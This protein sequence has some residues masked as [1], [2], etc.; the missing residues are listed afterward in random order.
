MG[1]GLPN[2]VG[3]FKDFALGDQLSL[4]YYI[5]GTQKRERN[6]M[7]DTEWV[8]SHHFVLYCS[9]SL[10]VARGPQRPCRPVVA[11][12]EFI[13][14]GG[15]TSHRLA[16][17]WYVNSGVAH[18]FIVTMLIGLCRGMQ[19]A[20]TKQTPDPKYLQPKGTDENEAR[21]FKSTIALLLT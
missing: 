10:L 2:R 4:G 7:F 17:L 5:Q 16:L 21:P 6:E 3:V 8:R 20:N 15:F 1:F 12:A 11:S 13:R 19:W 9:F 18:C 14:Q